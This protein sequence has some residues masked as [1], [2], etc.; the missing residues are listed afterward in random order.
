MVH[1]STTHGVIFDASFILKL[2]R[3]GSWLFD[4][5]LSWHSLI[6]MSEPME[7]DHMNRLPLNR[8]LNYPK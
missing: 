5:D 4:D 7:H 3:I 2:S 6:L 8:M 1:E